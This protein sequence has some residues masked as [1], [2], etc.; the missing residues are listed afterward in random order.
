MPIGRSSTGWWGRSPVGGGRVGH[1]RGRGRRGRVVL[2]S[3][4]WSPA[5][6]PRPAPRSWSCPRSPE[7][8][9]PE[10]EPEDP[11]TFLLVPAICELP[12]VS[13]TGW[14]W[15]GTA[16]A[17]IAPVGV[18]RGEHRSGH[19]VATLGREVDPV[20]GPQGHPVTGL[21]GDRR[22]EVAVGIRELGAHIDERDL[23]VLRGHLRDHAVQHVDVGVEIG[24]LHRGRSDPVDGSMSVADQDL[25][26]LFDLGRV[27]RGD[28]GCV[29][30]R[31]E[32]GHRV[33]VVGVD[34][35]H[36]RFRIARCHLLGCMFGPVE[37]LGRRE[38]RRDPWSRTAVRPHRSRRRSR[39][40][41]VPTIRRAS[42][43]RSTSASDPRR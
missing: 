2:R 32:V 19:A 26:H 17:E 41:R 6:P 13:T 5:G 36:H 28:L 21:V 39:R 16:C 4:G 27:L 7:P 25:H 11:L 12:S 8:D 42:R 20:G 18:D 37:E 22:G 3:A 34:D 14:V 31:L 10:P 29:V 38:T 35:E 15:P 1:R 9:E 24:I 43:R 30:G 23:G 40:A 33:R